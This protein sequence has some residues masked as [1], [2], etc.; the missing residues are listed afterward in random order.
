MAN[1]HPRFFFNGLGIHCDFA[2]AAS[3]YRAAAQQG[4]AWAQ[5]DFASI[6]LNG[7][8]VQREDTEAFKWTIQ[9]AAQRCNPL[10]RETC[11]SIAM[12][13]A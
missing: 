12:E 10:Q 2:E 6:Y 7:Q 11:T 3:R 9:S 4:L 8:R 5:T 13:R 1:F